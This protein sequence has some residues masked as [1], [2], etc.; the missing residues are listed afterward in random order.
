MVDTFVSI[1]H[2]LAVLNN[3][4]YLELSVRARQ[5]LMQYQLP[6]FK[7]REVSM[8][9]QLRKAVRTTSENDRVRA[10]EPLVVQQ[11]SLFDVLCQFIMRRATANEAKAVRRAALEVYIRRSYRTYEIKSISVSDDHSHGILVGEFQF[12][13]LD[14]QEKAERHDFMRASESA[15]ELTSHASDVTRSGLIAV[16]ADFQQLKEQFLSVLERFQPSDIMLEDEGINVMNLFVKSGSLESSVAETTKEMTTLLQRFRAELRAAGIRRLTL[17]VCTDGHFPK[18]YTYRE[19][20][21]YGEDMILRHMEP[22]LAF[23]LEL[24]RLSNY[25]ITYVRTLNRQ[26]HMYFG[27]EQGKTDSDPTRAKVLFVRTTVRQGDAFMH[28]QAR[29]IDYLIAQAERVILEGIKSLEVAIRDPRYKDSKNNH[30]FVKI[31][32]EVQYEP[33][34]VDKLIRALGNKYGQRL[35]KLNVGELELAGKVKIGGM[36]NNLRFVIRNPTGYA[37]EVDGYLEIKNATS[38]NMILEP[39]QLGDLGSGQLGGLPVDHPYA[40]T[41]TLERKRYAARDTKTTYVY[42][43]PILFKEA[44]K[45]RWESYQ[46]E[47]VAAGLPKPTMPPK[48]NLIEAT[49]LALGKDGSLRPVERPPGRNDIGMVAWKMT[50]RTPE[51]P[52]GRDLIVISNDITYMIGS[53]GPREDDLFKAASEMARVEGLPRIYISANSG[54]R[55]GLAQEVRDKFKVEWE[56]P[57]N[58]QKGFKYLY[59]TD[60]DYKDLHD[61]IKAEQ[62]ENGNWRI[63]DIIGIQEGLGV[64]NLRGSGMIAG[65]TSAAYDEI[66]TVTLV[67]GRSVGIGAYLVRLGQRVIQNDAPIILTGAAAINRLLGKSVYASNVQLGGPQIMFNN[68]V[69]HIDVNSDLRGVSSILRWLSFVPVSIGKP[70]PVLNIGDPVD[71]PIE[72][73]PTSTAY[74]PR[75]MLAGTTS[76]NGNWVSG[77]F[78]RGSWMETLS[79]WAMTVICGRARL[80]GIPMGVISVE[81][82]CVE[83]VIP[84]DPAN[85]ESTEVIVQKAGQVWFPD[86]AY[87]TAS[88]IQVCIVLYAFHSDNSYYSIF[89]CSGFQSRRATAF[90]YLRKL[91][92]ILWWHA[93]HVRRNLEVWFLHCRRAANLSATC[94]RLH[95]SVRRTSW[96]RLG[97]A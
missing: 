3:K 8:E 91:A 34:S 95:S 77:F 58:P 57:A 93:R 15:D 63:T 20:L 39:I 51:V 82:R 38:K 61:S 1:L 5:M 10:L 49:E 11:S 32:S 9:G 16:F 66:F 21:D 28:D 96:R 31:L 14:M 70:L 97:G 4:E 94:F 65:E 56:D 67:T 30:L 64:E 50:L 68:G 87:K 76:D 17:A 36:A 73:M 42:D 80:G 37:F 35:W 47:A 62:M 71:R 40:V 43:F 33:Q 13:A 75:H 72:F 60:E 52:S 41:S 19:R 84:A 48:N 55:I 25:D 81:T 12:V 78:D 54:A 26:I 83:H 90:D 24:Q 69:S 88:A 85:P 22:A 7:Q 6:S 46:R 44:L 2:D 27:K 86:S 23:Y 89:C 79:A 74:D 18:Y 53:F 45:D 29:S 92:W 59:V